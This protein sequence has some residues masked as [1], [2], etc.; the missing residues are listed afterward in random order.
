LF[1]GAR[2]TAAAGNLS[3]GKILYGAG[4]EMDDTKLKV[5]S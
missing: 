4:I 1:I 2:I 5:S 3:R